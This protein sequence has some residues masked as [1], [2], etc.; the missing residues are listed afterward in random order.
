MTFLI[1]FFLLLPFVNSLGN[2]LRNRISHFPLSKQHF[3]PQT[4]RLY[5]SIDEKSGYLDQVTKQMLQEAEKL[6]EEASNISQSP[7]ASDSNPFIR[8]YNFTLQTNI[9]VSNITLNGTKDV[10]FEPII[11]DRKVEAD[12]RNDLLSKLVGDEFL[13]TENATALVQTI[14]KSF[15]TIDSD[16]DTP[17]A[18][19]FVSEYF[20][21]SRQENAVG[22]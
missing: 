19:L 3:R 20:D 17:N 8:N 7:L 11:I 5:L 4:L 13:S 10:I 1:Y 18:E 22:E 12:S 9:D 21:K 15:E 16:I 6:K 14:M 2:D